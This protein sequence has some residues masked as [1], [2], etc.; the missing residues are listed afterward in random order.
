MIAYHTVGK[1]LKENNM[2]KLI[3]I[4]KESQN[5]YLDRLLDKILDQGIKS[6]TDEEKQALDQFSSGKNIKSPEEI[7]QELFNEWKQGEIKVGNNELENIYN[8]EDINNVDED[9]K[10]SFIDYTILVK[11]YPNI[12]KEDLAIVSSIGI[13]ILT[14]DEYL[15]ASIEYKNHQNNFTNLDE[16]TYYDILKN[17]FKINVKDIIDNLDKEDEP[18]FESIKS[19]PPIPEQIEILKK[20][21]FKEDGLN[22]NPGKYINFTYNFPDGTSYTTQPYFYDYFYRGKNFI[23]VKEFKKFKDFLLSFK[24]K[25]SQSLN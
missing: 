16:K 17:Y 25:K 23:P 18:D 5:D 9:L 24:E 6:L 14:G 20:L 4:L 2:I 13:G 12:Y 11:Q 7:M 10:Q 19:N 21:K 15:M 1:N 22:K 3:D 8:W